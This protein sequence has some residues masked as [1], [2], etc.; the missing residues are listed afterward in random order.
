MV[1]IH[2]VPWH[3]ENLFVSL[4]YSSIC[5]MVIA[6]VFLYVMV[7]ED[8]QINTLAIFRETSLTKASVSVAEVPNKSN[9]F[10]YDFVFRILEFYVVVEI[11]NIIMS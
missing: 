6:T 9:L 11:I 7:G 2:F 5:E 3:W 10:Y 1:L 4:L 8:V